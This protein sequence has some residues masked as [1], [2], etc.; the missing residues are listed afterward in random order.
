MLVWLGTIIIL[1]STLAVVAA[2]VSVAQD[3]GIGKVPGRTLGA[4]IV[5]LAFGLLNLT[6]VPLVLVLAVEG[7]S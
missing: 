7:M 3:L 6:V 2:G 1:S 4:E 5:G